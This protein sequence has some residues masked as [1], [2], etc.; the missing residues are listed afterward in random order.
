MIFSKS[1]VESSGKR[2][3]GSPSWM[4][5]RIRRASTR[6][7][8]DERGPNAR[9]NGWDDVSRADGVKIGVGGGPSVPPKANAAVTYRQ[10]HMLRR[11]SAPTSTMKEGGRKTRQ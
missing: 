6:R 5:S 7:L 9:R 1:T 8:R 10:S 2:A 11:Q 3:Q 4:P